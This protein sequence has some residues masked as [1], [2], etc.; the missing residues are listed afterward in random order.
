MQL[1]LLIATFKPLEHLKQSEILYLFILKSEK[2]VNL[3]Y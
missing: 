1:N 3:I 2:E